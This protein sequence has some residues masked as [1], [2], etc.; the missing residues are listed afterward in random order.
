MDPH[1]DVDTIVEDGNYVGWYL[2]HQDKVI[3]F[4]LNAVFIQCR[5]QVFQ[6]AM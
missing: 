4:H 5:H 1:A 2:Y 3:V 6:H